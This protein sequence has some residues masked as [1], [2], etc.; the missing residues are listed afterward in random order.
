[1]VEFS[2]KV[3]F[4]KIYV[5]DLLIGEAIHLLHIILNSGK[6]TNLELIKEKYINVKAM[7]G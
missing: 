4:A 6:G 3:D 5:K 1:M 7:N 2:Q